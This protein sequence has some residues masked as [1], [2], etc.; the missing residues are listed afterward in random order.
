MKNLFEI[1]GTA[2]A[3]AI[4]NVI[5]IRNW[6]KKNIPEEYISEMESS[7]AYGT[8]DVNGYAYSWRISKRFGLYMMVGGLSLASYN[9]SHIGS[10]C[11][12]Y[13]VRDGEGFYY[14]LGYANNYGAFVDKWPAIRQSILGIYERVKARRSFEP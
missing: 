5:K 9:D 3:I 7:G 8:F 11:G 4:H 1:E 6:V 13:G 2:D 12:A 10:G 14:L